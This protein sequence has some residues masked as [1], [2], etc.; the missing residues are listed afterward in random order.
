MARSRATSVPAPLAVPNLVGGE[1]LHLP[2]ELLDARRHAAGALP[3][4]QP[5]HQRAEQADD[6]GDAE[7]SDRGHDETSLA[8]VRSVASRPQSSPPSQTSRF[9]IG[10]DALS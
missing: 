10:T 5:D 9:Q 3:V 7:E 2:R 1:R 8:S 4:A 6:R